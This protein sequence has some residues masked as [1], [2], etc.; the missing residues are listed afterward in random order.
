MSPAAEVAPTASKYFPGHDAVVLLRV[1]LAALAPHVKLD[2]VASRG[3]A[4][5]PHLYDVPLPLSAVAAATVHQRG[6]DGDFTWP[7]MLDMY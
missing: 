5:F 2:A 7:A 3:G 1:D 6:L 4:L